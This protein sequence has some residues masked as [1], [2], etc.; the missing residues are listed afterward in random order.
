[1]VAADRTQAVLILAV[2]AMAGLIFPAPSASADV[3]LST[4]FTGRTVSGLTA[5]NITWTANGVTNPGDLTAVHEV[6]NDAGDLFD[7][8]AAQ[9]HF[10]LDNNVGNG[11]Q[12]S[13][14]FTIDV[15]GVGISLTDVD[16]DFTNFN[17]SGAKQGVNRSVAWTV[18]VDGSISSPISKQAISAS[19]KDGSV[20]IVFDSPIAMTGAESYDIRILA[21]EGIPNSGN[22]TGI[23]AMTFHGVIPEPATLA[24]L[25]LGGLAMLKRRRHA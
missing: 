15:T 2:V 10:A 13:T 14:T 9:G 7:T 4:D 5:S 25:G 8:A 20:A 22:N 21:Q 6:A 3:I 1:M 23:D 19:V 12:W 18:T 24:L 16:L 11:G 17:N